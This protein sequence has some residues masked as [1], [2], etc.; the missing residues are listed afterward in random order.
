MQR[1]EKEEILEK[2]FKECLFKDCGSMIRC[3]IMCAVIL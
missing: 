1:A 3:N 2:P